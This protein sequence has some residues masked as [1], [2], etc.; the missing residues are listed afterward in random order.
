MNIL[1][2]VPEYAP[3]I[4]GGIATYYGALAPAL[5]KQ[6]H[7]VRVIAGSAFSPRLESYQ[8]AGLTVEFLDPTEVLANL[9]QFDR[10]RLMPE[11]QRH[12]AAA[13]TAWE[14]ARGGAGF[15]V[16]ETTDWG[17]LF[18]PWVLETTSPPVLVQLHGSIGQIDFRDPS[19]GRE[20]E[21]TCVRL[22]ESGL[23]HYADGLQTLA[24]ANAREWGHQLGR[25]VDC[26]LPP[27]QSAQAHAEATG[28]MDSGVVVGRL[29]Y[30]KGAIVLCEALRLLGVDAPT[31]RWIGRSVALGSTG[32]DMAAHLKQTYPDVWGRT[33]LWVGPRSPLETTRLQASASFVLVPSVWDVFNF[34]CVEAM[35]A[36]RVVLCSR[37]AGAADL[38]EDGV[39]GLLFSP[40]DSDE[41]AAALRKLQTLGPAI[42]CSIGDAARAK[43]EHL[44]AP[45]QTA[46]Y[47]VKQYAALAQHRTFAHGASV[48][49]RA[50]VA[51]RQ[52][53]P[54]PLGALDQLPL[55][56]LVA[57]TTRRILH[58]TRD[59]IHSYA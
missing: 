45:D 31:I 15:D 58:R 48:W 34:T 14:R 37:G 17:L 6:G 49:L 41:L 30:W 3:L 32:Q 47:R 19:Q 40:D 13:W 29:Q 53:A 26:V 9:R 7:R 56:E 50:A 1:L 18:A 39:D 59:K 52:P 11:L 22:L 10:Y 33:L 27:W 21:G 57:Y 42:R 46:R 20:A 25:E 44:T 5:V 55:R 23:L 12:L 8:Q 2:V 54:Q 36:S 28:P 16:I 4:G 35:A 38:I 43:V 24:S 51:P